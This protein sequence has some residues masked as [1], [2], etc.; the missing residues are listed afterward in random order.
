MAPQGDNTNAKQTIVGRINQATNIL[1][2]VTKNPSIDSLAALLALTLMLNK[3]DKHATAVFSGQTPAVMQFLDP[4]K[5]FEGNV[6]SLRDFIISLDKE[7]ADRLRY[8]LEK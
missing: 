7:K 5:T 1:V 3:I 2:T 8:K 4:Q 6:D